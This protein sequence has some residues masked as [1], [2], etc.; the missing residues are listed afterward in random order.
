MDANSFARENYTFTGWNTAADGSGVNYYPGDTMVL[1]QEA[2]IFY[3]VWE[4]APAPEP[5]P[6]PEPVP[7]KP[8]EPTFW[9]KIVDFFNRIIRFFNDV[10]GV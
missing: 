2:T 9:Q 3:A 1:T 8:Q 7:E 5:K 6:E 4:K 10:F